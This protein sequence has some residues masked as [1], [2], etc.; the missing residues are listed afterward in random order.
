MNI[1]V[2]S[3]TAISKFLVFLFIQKKKLDDYKILV[4]R[5]QTMNPSIVLDDLLNEGYEIIWPN[6]LG[7]LS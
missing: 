1:A 3:K 4:I 7:Q 2:S 5:A 6:V